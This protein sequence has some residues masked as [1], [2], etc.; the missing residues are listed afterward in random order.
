MAYVARYMILRHG[1]D[2]VSSRHDVKSGALA[3]RL[4][5]NE[6]L[7]PKASFEG[8]QSSGGRAPQHRLD[9]RADDQLPV[10]GG[11][12]ACFALDEPQYLERQRKVALADAP[13]FEHRLAERS[14]VPRPDDFEMAEPGPAQHLRL[15]RVARQGGGHG[16]AHLVAHRAT[17]EP[18]KIDDN[19]AAELAQPQL[20]RDRPRR[21]Q[22]GR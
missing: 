7:P 21:F 12:R 22:I 17:F 10:R 1:S 8:A 6:N 20:T 5:G 13:R 15:G 3:V 9:R 18:D 2:I 11:A 4:G 19:A 16:L 14:P